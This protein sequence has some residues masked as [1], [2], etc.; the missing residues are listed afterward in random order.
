LRSLGYL[1]RPSLELGH[2]AVRE[3]M[4][5]MAP[6]LVGIGVYAID[7]VLARRFLSDLGL[8]A[9][10]YF[11]W[12]M[13]LC[14][15]PQGIFVMALSTAALPSLSSLAARGDRV[16]LGRTFAFGMRFSLFVAIP[17]TALLAGLAEPLVVL[18]FQRGEFDAVAA[19]ET[20]RSLVAQGLGIALVAAVRQLVGVFYAIGDTRTPVVVAAT[21]LLVFIG[22]ALSLRGPLGHVGVAWAVTGASFVQAALLWVM[23]SRR[24]P[25]TSHGLLGSTL[26][27]VLASLGAVAAGRGVVAFLSESGDAS[28]LGRALPGLGGALAFALAYLVL[29]WAFRSPELL[30]LLSRIRGRPKQGSND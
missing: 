2:P 16:E 25:I 5:R 26:R 20:A 30:A 6:T 24:V 19:H 22:L 18:L 27:V 29:A 21:D 1:E 28:A 23:L 15:F 7:V 11:N 17:A 4:R 12:A 3:V 8:G 14:D 10:S 9:Q 13:R